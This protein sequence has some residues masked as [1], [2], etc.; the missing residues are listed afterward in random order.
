MSLLKAQLWVAQIASRIEYLNLAFVDAIGFELFESICRSRE[1]DLIGEWIFSESL[2]ERDDGRNAAFLNRHRNTYG[3]EFVA[4]IA[5]ARDLVPQFI[6]DAC[7]RILSQSPRVVGF[8]SVFQQ[9]AASLWLAKKLKQSDSSLRIV[10][11]G[12]NCEGVMGETLSR[13]FDC[14]DTVVSGEA[15]C[16]ITGV[17]EGHLAGHRAM[18]FISGSAV[19]DLD[20]LPDPDFT[21]FF[22]QLGALA[23]PKAFEPR[24]L[25]ESA[26]GCWWG[27]KHHCTFCGL[28]GTTMAFRSKSPQRALAQLEGLVELYGIRCVGVVDNIMDMKYVQTLLPALARRD[29]GLDLL[30]E[31]KANLKKEQVRALS[32]AGVKRLQPGIESLSTPVL[33]IMRKGVRAIQNVQLLKWCK[34]LGIGVSWNVLWGFPGEDESDYTAMAKLVP[35]LRHLEPPQ[36]CGVMRLDRFSPNFENAS[37]SGLTNIRP[38]AAYEDVYGLPA[39]DLAGLAYYFTFDYSIERNVAAYTAPL[40]A[41]LVEW[42]ARWK[43]SELISVDYG[44]YLLIADWRAKTGRSTVLAALDRTLYLRC[45]EVCGMRRLLEIARAYGEP[46]TVPEL[47]QRLSPLIDAGLLLREGDTF[48]ALAIGLDEYV[49]EKDHLA[50]LRAM[51]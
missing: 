37:T 19:Q 2:R 36:A 1:T 33:R 13:V 41:A 23:D 28:N 24:L 34:Q 7:N 42:R 3:A 14:V 40:E 30:Y 11:G 12:A 25:V 48:L 20:V 16:I 26:R 51:A 39:V 17:I 44:D 50:S 43:A 32:A 49:A 22:E 46:L 29:L 18:G 8:T 47:E 31:V 10:F 45:D 35:L 5:R 21:D 38:Y 6:D 15:D 9:H 27:A 4:G